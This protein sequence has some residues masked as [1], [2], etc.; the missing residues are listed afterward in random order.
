MFK[1]VPSSSKVSLSLSAR[2]MIQFPDL[3]R[4]WAEF[5][6]SGAGPSQVSWAGSLLIH[7]GGLVIAE[8]TRGYLPKDNNMHRV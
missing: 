3:F 8:I 2:L 6:P 4:A 1:Y 5:F 7:G